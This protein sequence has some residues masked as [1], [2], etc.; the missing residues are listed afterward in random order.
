MGLST[1][2]ILLTLGFKPD[3]RVH[4]GAPGGL[5]YSFTGLRLMASVTLGR[6]YCPVIFFSGVAVGPGRR[7]IAEVEFEMPE[8]VE[9]YEQ[10]VA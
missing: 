3:S 1:Y 4:S 5:S 10:G 2:S 6:A 8:E 9:S 7:S